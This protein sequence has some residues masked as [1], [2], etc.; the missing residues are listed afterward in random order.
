[1]APIDD[2]ITAI[3]LKAPGEEL[4]YRAVAE[5]FNVDR[6]TLSRRHRGRQS[7]RDTQMAHQHKINAEQ[8]AELVQYINDLT[9]RALPPTRAMVND[10][11]RI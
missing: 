3:E 9:E 2:A 6:T 1:M 7:S 5:M 8:E 4:S 11:R 10:S